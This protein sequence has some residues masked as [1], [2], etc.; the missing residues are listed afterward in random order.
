MKKNN[1]VAFSRAID[2]L[3]KVLK[4]VEASGEK[5]KTEEDWEDDIVELNA[6]IQ[7]LLSMEKTYLSE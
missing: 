1:K 2:A 3:E 5:A 6:T 7:F 4:L